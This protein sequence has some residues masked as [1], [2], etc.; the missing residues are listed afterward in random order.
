MLDK[1]WLL[2]MTFYRIALIPFIS[3]CIVVGRAD[4]LPFVVYLVHIYI[5]IS[6]RIALLYIANNGFLCSCV[7]LYLAMRCSASI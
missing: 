3:F 4:S 2:A 1:Y 7:S 6:I 5:S